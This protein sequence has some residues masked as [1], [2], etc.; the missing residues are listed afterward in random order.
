MYTIILN[1]HRG[2]IPFEAF[3]TAFKY[4]VQGQNKGH[5]WMEKKSKTQNGGLVL[6]ELVEQGRTNQVLIT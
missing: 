2:R 5:I 3:K 1:F 6:N 4:G